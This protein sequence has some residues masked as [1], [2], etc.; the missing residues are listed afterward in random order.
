MAPLYLEVFLYQFVF[1][2]DTNIFLNPLK[3]WLLSTM[4]LK[5]D[6]GASPYTHAP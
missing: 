2:L 3:V 6:T 1:G 5:V 4:F